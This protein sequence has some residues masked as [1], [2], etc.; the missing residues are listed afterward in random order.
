MTLFKEYPAL[1]SNEAVFIHTISVPNSEC[2][3]TLFY[4]ETW[5]S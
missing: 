2:T 4:I 1:D 3:L 5:N